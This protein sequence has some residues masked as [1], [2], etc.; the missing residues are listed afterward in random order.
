VPARGGSAR[1]HRIIIA[2]RMTGDAKSFR[3]ELGE[4]KP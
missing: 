3:A 4:A 2:G 1:G